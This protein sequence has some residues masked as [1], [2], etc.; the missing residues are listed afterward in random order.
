MGELAD[1]R[2]KDNWSAYQRAKQAGH[3]DYVELA[4]KCNRFYIGGGEQWDSE[5]RARLEAD[6]RPALEINM[7]LS[8]VNTILGEQ[9]TQR[10]DIIFKPRKN[11]NQETADALTALV[12]Q[13]QDN[14]KYEYVESQVFSDGIIQDRGYFDIRMDFSDHIQGEVRITA[15]DPVNILLDPNANEYD[16]STW[17]EVTESKWMS[18]DEIESLYGK[19]AA[20]KI[21]DFVSANGRAEYGSDSIRFDQDNFGDDD[22][23]SYPTE[24]EQDYRRIRRVRVIERQWKKLAMVRYF[25]D[26]ETGDMRQVPD[27]MDEERMQM[28]MGIANLSVI[29]RM[30]QRIRWT[31]STDGVLIHDEWSPY[32]NFT[33]VPYFPYFRRGKPFGVVRNLISPQE[34]LNKIESQELHIINTTA[35]SGWVV[36]AGSLVNMTEEEL[37]E[38]GAETGLVLTYA[39]GKEPPAKIKANS[40]PTGI[41]RVAGKAADSIRTISGVYGAM[42]GEVNPEVSGVA[43]KLGAARGSMQLQVPLDNLTKTRRIVAQRVLEL[44]Q[45]YYTETRVFQ[46]IDYNDPAMGQKEVVVNQPTVAGTIINDITMGEYNVIIANAPARDSMMETQFAEAIQLRE[47]GVQIPDDVVIENSH[48]NRKMEIAERVRQL[49]GMGT[50]TPEQQQEAMMMKQFQMQMMQLEMAEL[51][52]KVMKMQSEAQQ[53]MAKAQTGAAEA[54][55]MRMAAMAEI[56]HRIESLRADMIKHMTNLQ[57]KAELAQMHIDSKMQNTMYTTAAKKMMEELKAQS[58]IAAKGLQQGT[59]SSAQ[60]TG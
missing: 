12:M 9:Q 5:D 3:D 27:D 28:L 14:N 29:R 15:K 44:V 58:V 13:I 17:N 18:V 55:T 39:P 37:E 38:R 8:T 22:S 33:I 50:P 2:A 21:K 1:K 48:L 41:D 40:I 43:M 35:N 20:D 53:G 47:A 25:V 56:Q 46:V 11:A 32:N 57:N 30:T 4:K 52:A 6:G 19:K 42:V 45:Q 51:E 10:A 24:D 49:M 7:I 26:N 31:V 36:E 23:V 54:E 60:K 59:T 34:Q 16:P